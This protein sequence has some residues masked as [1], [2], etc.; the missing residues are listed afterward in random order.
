MVTPQGGDFEFGSKE[1]EIGVKKG[2]LL[3]GKDGQ[4]EGRFELREVIRMAADQQGH[5]CMLSVVAGNAAVR[6]VDE[7]GIMEVSRGRI[8]LSPCTS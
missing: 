8:Q 2:V 3:I 1:Q 4:K 6:L 7:E 5:V